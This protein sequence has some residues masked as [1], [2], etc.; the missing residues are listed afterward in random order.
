MKVVIYRQR[1]T[2]IHI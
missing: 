1:S 2:S